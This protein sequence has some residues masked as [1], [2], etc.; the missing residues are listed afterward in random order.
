MVKVLLLGATGN[1][2]RAILRQLLAD[3]KHPV[4]ALVRSPDRLA[5]AIGG[6]LA[7]SRNLSVVRGNILEGGELLQLMS[8]HGVCICAAGRPGDRDPGN[9]LERI[10]AAVVAGAPSLMAPRKLIML[11][12]L[13]ALS[14]P[15]AH[16]PSGLLPLMPEV[17]RGY[18]RVHLKDYEV[19]ARLPASVSWTLLCPGMM[20]E[21]PASPVPVLP[22]LDVN[23]VFDNA[24]VA[25]VL[26]ALPAVASAVYM[27]VNQSRITIPYEDAAALAVQLAEA[28]PGAPYW[29]HRVGLA[30]AHG[31][32]SMGRVSN[33][34]LTLAVLSF[35][36]T[37]I[38]YGVENARNTKAPP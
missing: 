8:T 18:T 32:P 11:G 7:A 33:I 20:V 15:G 12:G 2:G 17:L 4:T 9:D 38:A 22:N 5:S 26:A 34:I 3:T 31:P 6:E 25:R 36:F 16:G 21:G 30:R 37:M 28:A 23:P 29:G 27:G 1:L 19:L 10:F 14:A 35:L 24:L 13:G